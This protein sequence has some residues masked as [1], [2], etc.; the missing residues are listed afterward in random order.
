MYHFTLT[1]VYCTFS[2]RSLKVSVE[3]VVESILPANGDTW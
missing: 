1:Y 3:S 2:Q